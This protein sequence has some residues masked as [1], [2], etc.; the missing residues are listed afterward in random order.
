MTLGHD[1]DVTAYAISE[2]E[3]LNED[4]AR[5]YRELA[6]AAI[7]QYGGEYIVRGASPEVPEGSWPGNQRVVVVRF[8][9][10][11]Q[12]HRWYHSPEYAK[13]LTVRRTALK[14]RLLFVPGLD[15]NS[16]D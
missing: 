7:E 14:R 4:Q 5:L 8:P 9:T 12:L 11:E 1:Q 16:P 2:V 3:V 10:M 13:A 6:S 15:E